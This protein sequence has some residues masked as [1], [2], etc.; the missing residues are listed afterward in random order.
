VLGILA[1]ISLLF[2]A[3]V[4]DNDIEY[5]SSVYIIGLLLQIIG[6][7]IYWIYFGLSFKHS[8]E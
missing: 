1:T 8:E 7:L 5:G 4:R 6:F 2:Y 3:V